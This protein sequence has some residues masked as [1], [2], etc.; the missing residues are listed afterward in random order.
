[1]AANEATI[2]LTGDNKSALAAITG[3]KNGLNGLTSSVEAVNQKMQQL[4]NAIV[5][6]GIVAF[7]QQLLV[8]ADTLKDLSAAT[9]VS[10]QNLL[11]M[12]IA[13]LGANSNLEGLA[14]MLVRLEGN[15]GEALAG[16]IQM[17][18][19]LEQVGIGFA[20]IQS[21][22]P[23][24]IFD[25]I[26][27]S[28]AKTTD[29]FTRA[30]LAAELFGK[31][32]RLFNWADYK[33]SID[34]LRGTMKDFA[35]NQNRAADV[36]EKL[37]AFIELLKIQF[38]NLL[39]PILRLLTPVGQMR[40]TMDTAAVVA[41]VLAGAIA[42]I[43][44]S[45]TINL[46]RSLAAAFSF[47]TG[48]MGLGTVAAKAENAA[49]KAG[50]AELAARF[51]AQKAFYVEKVKALDIT[52]A[53]TRANIAE[54]NSEIGV[55][56]AQATLTAALKVRNTAMANAAGYTAALGAAENALAVQ[57]VKTTSAFARLTAVV[58]AIGG[59]LL[60]FVGI[61]G[62]PV[63]ATVAAGIAAI[64]VA[65]TAGL[66]VWRAFSKEIKEFAGDVYKFLVGAFKTA[67]E[68]I[69]RAAAGLRKMFG[70]KPIEIKAEV[71]TTQTAQDDA[72]K[73][74]EKIKAALNQQQIQAQEALQANIARLEAEAPYLRDKIALGE[75]EANIQK[76]IR[77]EQEKINK[78]NETNKYAKIAMLQTDKDRITQA[79]KETALANSHVS[80]A[81]E[82]RALDNEN[83]LLSIQDVG[84]REIQ[85][86]L[87]E[88]IMKYGK[89]IADEDLRAYEASLKKNQAL[90]DEEMLRKAVLEASGIPTISLPAQAAAGVGIAADLDPAKKLKAQYDLQ[91]TY[92][93]AARNQDKLTEENY[94]NALAALE[95]RYHQESLQL[96]INRYQMVVDNNQRE[97]DAQAA[98]YAAMIRMQKDFNGEQKWTNAE[99][100]QM[101]KT[102]AEFEAKTEQQ[103]AQW[104]IAQIETVTSAA[105]AQSKT[106][107]R[108]QQAASIGKAIMN[109]YEGA[110]K[111]L[112]EY[113]PPWSYIAMAAVVASGMAQ[114]AQIR[115]QSY[116]GRALGGPMVGGQ[117]Y[118]VGEKGPELFTPGQSGSMTPNDQIGGG[119]T[120]VN[121]TIVA[122][123]TRGFDDLLLARKNMIT[124]IIADA[125]L[126]KGRRQT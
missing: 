10:T 53:L 112:A 89:Y 93:I 87:R 68:Y 125:Q 21:L 30:R 50:T 2:R 60:A 98:K 6:V 3:V 47:L 18:R 40:D 77:E 34:A 64:T 46:V 54:M 79:V 33:G 25:R 73:Q 7:T 13:A 71:K 80:I 27:T 72:E 108:M 52:I 95:I 58:T 74:N 100:L 4:T 110:T 9:D 76:A 81:Q 1:M 102:R 61:I 106:L 116:A 22:R 8:G 113:P 62:A 31:A 118:L 82:I 65:V 37:Q 35:D 23:N 97:I 42:L 90:R 11:E 51:A 83:L 107:F 19:S 123:D 63:W 17:Q 99:A 14:N 103:K 38:L 20:E 67:L 28:L 5:G 126:E 55:A 48:A 117:T 88:Q 120:N 45:T 43:V 109:T 105:T 85:S 41:K 114:V 36:S 56:R 94:R 78:A 101:G 115:S 104:A 59:A 57:T 44:A 69:D 122:N 92:L 124:R 121:F 119:V 66:I 24:E 15:I 32:G 96:E 26:A 86:K 91:S 111:A 16:N 29:S 49:L 84:Q 39:D 12:S 70:L 75:V